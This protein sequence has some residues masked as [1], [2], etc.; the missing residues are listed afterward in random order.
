[1]SVTNYQYWPF[2]PSSAT[3]GF[4]LDDDKIEFFREATAGGF[5]AFRFGVNDYGA[6]SNGR[7]GCILERGRAQWEIRLSE[8]DQRRLVAYVRDFSAAGRAV[9]AWL[10]GSDARQI[11]ANLHDQL[12]T[13]A[14]A[15]ASYRIAHS[16]SS[17]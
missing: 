12:V 11:V 8:G 2:D 14:G 6:K 1:M 10:G 5:E 3:G 4:V 15:K 16:D 13:P 7:E 9:T 17:Q